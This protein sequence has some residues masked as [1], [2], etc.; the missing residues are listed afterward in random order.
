[1]R[2]I[3]IPKSVV[4]EKAVEISFAVLYEQQCAGHPFW[5]D[6]ATGA[7]RLNML[8]RITKKFGTFEPGLRVR[9]TDKEHEAIFP[10]I[11]MK[12]KDLP[13][14]LGLPLS[15]LMLCMYEAEHEED[16][17]ESSLVGT[18]PE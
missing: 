9:L 16:S 18:S 2:I 8:F 14:G 7:D 13:P 11:T 1:M 4:T 3:T 10:L 5:R 6:E 17:A 15:R 12:G